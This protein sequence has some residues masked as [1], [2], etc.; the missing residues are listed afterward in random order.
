YQY[1]TTWTV[2]SPTQVAVDIRLDMRTFNNPS[3]VD[4]TTSGV[5]GDPLTGAQLS[6]AYDATK[7]TFSEGL[8]V[9]APRI[10]AGPTVNGT[11]AGTVSL[12]ATTT[13]LATGNMGIA[14]IVFDRV[15]GATGSVG[16]TTTFNSF[17]TRTGGVTQ[18][19]PLASVVN[20]E[21]TF[22]LP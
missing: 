16:T 9:A 13:T 6:F 11:V 19:I 20:L 12:I 10:T 17:A 21:G 14:R 15:P 7:L 2:L 5:T 18:A 22:V 3:V 4:V 8:G 1:N